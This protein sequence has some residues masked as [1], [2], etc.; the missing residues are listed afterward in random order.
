V[1]RLKRDPASALRAI[2]ATAVPRLLASSVGGAIVFERVANSS[3][4][5][6]YSL[7]DLKQLSVLA[8]SLRP[9]S[10]VSFYFD[11]R[12]ATGTYGA[13]V[14]REILRTAAPSADVIIGALGA[15]GLELDIGYI[16]GER[17]LDDYPE[18][19]NLGATVIYG[20]Y[21]GR[22]DDGEN[23]VTLVLPDLDGVVRG[24]PY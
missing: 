15:D 1:D 24:H 22:D 16:C 19:L 13:D 6:W 20:P 2:E 18:I 5:R 12:I 14:R 9:G 11:G 17:D 3:E 8:A 7:R 4:T 23:A 21:P 10:M